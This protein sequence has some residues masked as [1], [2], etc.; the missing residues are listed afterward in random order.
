MCGFYFNEQVNM[1]IENDHEWSSY[2][3]SVDQLYDIKDKMCPTISGGW[4]FFNVLG[5]HEQNTNER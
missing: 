1:T 3:V 2:V 5:K 4:N